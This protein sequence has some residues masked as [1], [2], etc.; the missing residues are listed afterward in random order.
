MDTIEAIVS[1]R[2]NR[3][4]A[5]D[6]V[7]EEKLK[8]IIEA[9]RYAPSG[10]N[11]QSNHFLVVRNKAVLEKLAVLAKD[12]FSKMEITENTYSSLKI[13][14]SLS[15]KGEYVFHYNAPVLII[16]A[17]QKDYGNN[18]ADSAVAAENMMI[19]ANELDLASCWI[20]QIH[21][22]TEDE[23]MLAYLKELGLKDSERVYA[24]VAIGYPNTPD[25]IPARAPLPR[26][27]NEVTY[28]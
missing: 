12:A 6:T 4:F 15:K 2:S 5:K 28:I 11:N 23:N 24:S 1:R 26:K 18:I 13:S 21:W 22:L 10:G 3:S 19:A 17:N 16:I 9:G 14:I 25:K 20:N 8:K 7:E 27:G